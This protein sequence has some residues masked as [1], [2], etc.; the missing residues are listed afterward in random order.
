MG[1]KCLDKDGNLCVNGSQVPLEVNDEVNQ[2]GLGG[3][4]D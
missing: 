4:G 1:C 3:T 2:G